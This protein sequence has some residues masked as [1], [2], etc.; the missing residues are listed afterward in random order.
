MCA[1]LH[2]HKENNHLT[3]NYFSQVAKQ[4]LNSANILMYA[5]LQYKYN[6]NLIPSLQTKTNGKAI[7]H[8]HLWSTNVISFNEHLAVCDIGLII[9]GF[10][11]FRDS[12]YF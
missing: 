7:M 10:F 9:T 6:L 3:F 2:V 11:T 8:P 1:K 4:V 12:V 5:G